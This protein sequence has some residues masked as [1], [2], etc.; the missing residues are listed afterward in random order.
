[1]QHRGRARPFHVLGV[2]EVRRGVRGGQKKSGG[3]KSKQEK[4]PLGAKREAGGH[5]ST[6]RSDFRTTMK[7][8]KAEHLVSNFPFVLLK[9]LNL[10][11]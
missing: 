10:F 11:K 5:R 2:D 7:V 1:M 6:E 3:K 8:H 9:L 4:G